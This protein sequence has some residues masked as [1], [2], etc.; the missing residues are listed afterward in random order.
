MVITNDL[1]FEKLENCVTIRGSL[2]FTT[3][4]YNNTSFPYLL[5][6][7]GFLK[8]HNIDK[9][10]SVK[11]L[12]PNLAHID[13]INFWTEFGVSSENSH[14][15]LVI[16][17]NKHLENLG[18]GKFMRIFS[19]SVEIRGNPRFCLSDMIGWSKLQETHTSETFIEVRNFKIIERGEIPYNE[20]YL[21]FKNRL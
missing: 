4:T 3:F 14:M 7:E 1:Q 9:L 10:L 18:F 12:L 16:T 5:Y 11:Q 15:A 8:I 19:G 6:I 21:R 20:A 13:G 17:D 2:T